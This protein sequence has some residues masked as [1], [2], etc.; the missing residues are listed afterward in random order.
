M[1]STTSFR[2]GGWTP[3]RRIATNGLRISFWKEKFASSACSRYCSRTIMSDVDAAP[4]QCVRASDNCVGAFVKLCQSIRTIVSEVGNIVSEVGAIVSEVGTVVI[5]PN[6]VRGGVVDSACAW[7]NNF[8][9]QCLTHWSMILNQI[10]SWR[11]EYIGSSLY[12]LK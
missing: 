10:A 5:L 8:S 9:L 7:L 2:A 6:M 1:H 3:L 4:I 12:I 11:S